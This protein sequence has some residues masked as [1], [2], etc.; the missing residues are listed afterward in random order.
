MNKTIVKL[1]SCFIF[2]KQ[3]RQDFRRRHRARNNRIIV[4]KNDWGGG[5]E[6]PLLKDWNVFST[7][8]ATRWKYMNRVF[9]N[10]A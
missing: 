4:Y 10:A 5:I 8:A 3:A 7:A 6:F 2:S 9:L 1:L